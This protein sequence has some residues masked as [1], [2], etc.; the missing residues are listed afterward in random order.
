MD[1]KIIDAMVEG[2]ECAI[3]EDYQDA[4]LCESKPKRKK[5]IPLKVI[6]K[7]VLKSCK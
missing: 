2:G 5:R 7:A 4:V 6:G 1:E 3:G